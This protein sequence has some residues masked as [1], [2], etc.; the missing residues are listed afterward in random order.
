[1]TVDRYAALA[2]ITASDL[3]VGLWDEEI[4]AGLDQDAA[5]IRAWLADGNDPWRH[6]VPLTDRTVIRVDAQS[7]H[8]S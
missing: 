2:A 7:D 1:M 8:D 3:A 4:V 5:D 6:A